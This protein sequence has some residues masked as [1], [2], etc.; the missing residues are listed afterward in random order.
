MEKDREK[1]SIPSY[2]AI[3]PADVRYNKNITANAKLLYGE[4]TALCNKEG[5]CWASNQYF[6]TLYN[7]HKDTISKWVSEL[8]DEEYIYFTVLENN[9]RQIF[10][11]GDR[12]KDLPY[13]QK[14]LGGTAKTPRGD[15]QK[16]LHNN[17]MNNKE[18]NVTTKIIR[19]P[20]DVMTLNEFIEN[21]RKSPMKHIQVVAEWAEGEK[22][23]HQTYGEWNAFLKR[24]IR[25]A[26]ELSPYSIEKIEKAYQLLQ[27]DVVKKLPNG[28]T[29]GFIT[30]YS[31]ETVLKYIDNV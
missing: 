27:K 28:K 13:R 12:Q 7:V 26:K 23:K 19:K 4:I 25:A 1:S 30:K 16:R 31:L 22:P 15:R 18:N 21:C 11:N 6:A 2:Y 17:T 10:L 8:V 24:N 20:D 3:I 29:T 5:F 9:Y 14:R